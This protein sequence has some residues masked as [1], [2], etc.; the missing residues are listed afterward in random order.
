MF[1]VSGPDL[2][3][4]ACRAGVVG[5]F[6]TANAGDAESLDAWLSEIG[7]RLAG[8]AERRPAPY[9]PNLIIRDPRCQAHAAVLAR[10]RPE[11]VITSVGSPAPVLR[12]LHD[13]GSLVFADVGSM[14]HAEKAIGDG[15]DGLIL[16]SAGAGGNTGWL[17]PF[18]FVRAVRAIFD[19]P[20][21]LAGGMTD[22]TSIRAAEMLGC[23]LVYVGTRFIAARESLASPDYRDM[24]VAA[25]M[26]D[27]VLTRAFSGIDASILRSSLERAGLDLETLPLTP[28]EEEARNAYGAAAGGPRRWREIWSAGH[29]VSGVR[30]VQSV[31]EIVA[32]L[33]DS[34]ETAG[35]SGAG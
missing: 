35:T 9:C 23:D 17:N 25:S 3:V 6:P 10:H 33:A 26:D 21:V 27:V 28:T 29:S 4:A 5:A 18:A 24:V 16:L 14:R 2:V 11:L 32:D 12:R 19:G 22:G 34:Y 7:H 1:R 20:I 13:A 8:P 30:A 31:G 15:V